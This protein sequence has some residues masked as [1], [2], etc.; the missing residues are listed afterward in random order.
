MSAKDIFLNWMIFL[1]KCLLLIAAVVVLVLLFRRLSILIKRCIAA[2]RIEKIAKISGY[3]VERKRFKFLRIGKKNAPT[4]YVLTKKNRKI[5]VHFIATEGKA[6]I[7]RF[8]APD[9]YAIEKTVGFFALNTENAFS[10][11]TAKMFKPK[12]MSGSTLQWAH[13]D[14]TDLPVGTVRLRGMEDIEQNKTCGIE[15]VIILNPAPMKAFYLAAN[16]WQ[17]IVGGET[18]FGIGYHTVESFCSTLKRG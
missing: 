3:E 1:G 17:P 2:R 13:T 9:A 8:F 10:L 6:R 18:I 7:L 5:H 4:A 12:N 14:G 15:D 11:S 16:S